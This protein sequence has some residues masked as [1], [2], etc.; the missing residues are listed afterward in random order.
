[1]GFE[2]VL[3]VP[4]LVFSIVIHEVSHGW[5]ALWH[6]DDTAER[7]GRLTLNPVPHADLFGT[8]MLPALCV[9]G[10]SP[11]FGWAKPVPVDPRRLRGRRAVAKVSLAG[12][13]SNV[14][15]AALSA[16]LF[17][18]SFAIAP[19]IGDIQP[20]L[21]QALRF[22][23]ILNLYLAAFNLVPVHPLDGSQAVAGLLPRRLAAA[24]EAH[25][26]YGYLIILLLM[27]TGVL[28]AL[29]YPAVAGAFALFR[30]IGLIW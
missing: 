25:A 15:L 1:M 18:L 5:T 4:I 12:P 20:T 11:V 2:W 7:A 21:A 8:F 16:V 22:G 19:L 27:M 3:Q 17:R 14:A 24:Y 9:L 28:G 6:G 29:L 30:G 23:F 26:P 10:G 13:L